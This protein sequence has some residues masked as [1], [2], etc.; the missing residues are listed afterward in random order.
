MS[1][2]L[3]SRIRTIERFAFRAAN[4]EIVDLI[5]LSMEQDRA[6]TAAGVVNRMRAGDQDRRR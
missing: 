1:K 6:A 4:N 3:V 2:Q 5:D